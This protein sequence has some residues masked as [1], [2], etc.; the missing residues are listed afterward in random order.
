M[1]SVLTI[2]ALKGNIFLLEF[3][4]YSLIFSPFDFATSSDIM[5]DP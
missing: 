5:E 2:R 4:E 1:L 3:Q